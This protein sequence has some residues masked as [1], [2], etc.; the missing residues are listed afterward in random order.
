VLA[1][2][3]AE[4]LGGTTPLKPL[5]DDAYPALADLATRLSLVLLQTA[6][7][8]ARDERSPFIEGA[9]VKRAH[10]AIAKEFALVNKLVATKPLP[11]AQVVERLA[12]LTRRLIEGKIKALQT[13]N[14][15]TK[16]LTRDLNRVSKIPL[17]DEAV[18]VWMK[19]LQSFAHFVAGGYDPMQADNF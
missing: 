16:D 12:P 4:I 11:D 10:A 3:E 7:T 5:V 1:V 15:D 13:F 6:G 18:D 17:S 19:D 14:K 8:I 9:H 2:I